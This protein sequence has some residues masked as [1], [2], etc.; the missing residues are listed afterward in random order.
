MTR[1]YSSKYILSNLICILVI[2]LPISLLIGSFVI[3][4]ITFFIALFFIIEIF[5]KK[6]I[7][8]LN[9]WSFFLLLFLWLSF[10]IN[11]FF[12]QNFELGLFRSVGFI[13]FIFFIQAIKYIFL[14]EKINYKKFILQSW[15]LIFTIVSFDLLIEYITGQNILGFKSEFHGRLGSFL[16]YEYKIGAFYFSFAIISFATIYTYINKNYKIIFTLVVIFLIIS[17]LIGERSNFFK[18]FISFSIILILYFSKYYKK[19]ILLLFASVLLLTSIIYSNENLKYRYLVQ[20]N[21]KNI[22]ENNYITHYKTA[23]FVFQ[24]YPFFGSG[25][26][27]FRVEVK[28]IINKDYKDDV[29]YNNVRILTTHP[30]QI[31]FEILSETGFFGYT[32]FL[33]FFIFTFVK[34]FKEFM[35]KRNIFLLVSTV[36]CL[37]YINPVLPSGS[38]FTTYGATIFWTNYAILLS[39]IKSN[40]KID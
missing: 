3:N 25:I 36:F 18:F 16:G 6:K 8:F 39:H 10:L 34:A 4:I 40:K 5:L 20:W 19:I 22:N 26:K 33:I 38:F 15:L 35:L 30:H 37:I 28:K 21:L 2:I 9:N 23:I 24:K 27:N 13:K 12:S 31:N 1:I 11:L 32:C 29:K 14:F 17:F 7:N